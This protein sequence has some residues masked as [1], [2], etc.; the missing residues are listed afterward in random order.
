MLYAQ[1]KDKT[2]WPMKWAKCE[3]MF[4]YL[5]RMTYGFQ[6]EIHGKMFATQDGPE[7]RGVLIKWVGNYGSPVRD[8][9][10]EV[11]LETG[12]PEQMEAAL[13][14]LINEAEQAA[15]AAYDKRVSMVP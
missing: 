6:L 5:N 8:M 15:K 13:F 3:D 1:V 11:L 14:M 10:R 12:D 2:M 4:K 9:Q 7:H